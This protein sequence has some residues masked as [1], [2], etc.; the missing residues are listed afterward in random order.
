MGADGPGAAPSS[1]YL[2]SPQVPLGS[3]TPGKWNLQP[4]GGCMRGE[5]VLSGR[6]ESNPEPGGLTWG[7]GVGTGEG[8]VSGKD[9]LGLWRL[10]PPPPAPWGVVTHCRNREAT[11]HTYAHPRGGRH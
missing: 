2:P 8:R 4:L 5:R 6:K 7:W 9:F 1:S 3:S 10:V 11:P